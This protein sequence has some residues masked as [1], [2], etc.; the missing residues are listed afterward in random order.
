VA[1]TVNEEESMVNVDWSKSFNPFGMWS[2]VLF[3]PPG[4]T[5]VGVLNLATGE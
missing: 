1:G 4:Q 3:T 2:R 5:G